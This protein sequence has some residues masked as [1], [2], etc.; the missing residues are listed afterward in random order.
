MIADSN[1][2]YTALFQPPPVASKYNSHACSFDVDTAMSVTQVFGDVTRTVTDKVTKVTR[3][4]TERVVVNNTVTTSVNASLSCDHG[5]FTTSLVYHPSFFYNYQCSSTLVR[6]YSPVFLTMMF[7]SSFGL[8][9]CYFIALRVVGIWP[10]AHPLLRLIPGVLMRTP[11]ELYFHKPN[12]AWHEPPTKVTVGTHSSFVLDVHSVFVAL[13]QD[14]MILVTFGTVAPLVG[15]AVIA[16]IVCRT[17]RLHHWILAFHQRGHCVEH[18]LWDLQQFGHEKEPIFIARWFLLVFSAVF[19][20]LFLVDTGGDQVGWKAAVWLPL[21]MWILPVVGALIANRFERVQVQSAE[22][23]LPSVRQITLVSAKPRARA[24]VSLAIELPGRVDNPLR[25]ESGTVSVSG[26][27]RL[28]RHS[29]HISGRESLST[30]S[31]SAEGGGG[32]RRSSFG[33]GSGPRTSSSSSS[34]SPSRGSL[35]LSLSSS[36]LQAKL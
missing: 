19:L 12:R 30:A 9:L 36:N 21:L 31:V 33:G 35:R 32:G 17:L 16:S 28:S 1:C 22:L 10:S 6:K 14:L 13:L 24:S 2:F 34:S 4:F 3:T 25:R 7:F 5:D 27:Q 8:P 11:E 15:L 18:L 20:S 29:L 23:I 26:S